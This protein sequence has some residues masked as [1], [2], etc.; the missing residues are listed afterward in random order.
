MVKGDSENSPFLELIKLCHEEISANDTYIFRDASIMRE[1]QSDMFSS[2]GASQFFHNTQRSLDQMRA[3]SS[4]RVKICLEYDQRRSLLVSAPE[5][6]P[7]LEK[8][9]STPP[10]FAGL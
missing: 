5:K 6:A 8:S 9:K 4:K 3:M 1:D 10:P 7:D 2:A